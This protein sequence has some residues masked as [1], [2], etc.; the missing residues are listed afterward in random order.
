MDS[1]HSVDLNVQITLAKRP[2]PDYPQ[3]EDVFQIKYVPPQPTDNV[4]EGQVIVR[5]LFLSVDATMRVWISGVKSYMEPIQPGDIMRGMGVSEVI[6]SR[7][8]KFK[9]GDTVLALTYWQK[10]SV[11]DGKTLTLLPKNYP[12]PDHFMGVLGISGLTAYFGFNKI[13]KLKAG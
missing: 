13:G 9:V 6:Y 1:G 7:N 2:T 8:P 12:H 4:L 10:Y 5:N 11:L 3:N